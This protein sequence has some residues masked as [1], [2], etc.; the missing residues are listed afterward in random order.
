MYRQQVIVDWSKMM[1]M[2]VGW[3]ILRV[4]LILKSTGF[5]NAL[6]MRHE[7]KRRDHVSANVTDYISKWV[8]DR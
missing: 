7:G 2:M 8:T 3:F 6:G 1:A 5:L 4:Y